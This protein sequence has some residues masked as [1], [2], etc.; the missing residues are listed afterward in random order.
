M[1]SHDFPQPQLS[2]QRYLEAVKA[3]LTALAQCDAAV[4]GG[5]IA[6][7]PTVGDNTLLTLYTLDGINEVLEWNNEGAAAD[8]IA[9]IWLSLLRWLRTVHHINPDA[10]PFALDRPLDH[11]LDVAPHS[12]PNTVIEQ[13][14]RTGE[15]QMID[16][17]INAD[18][19]DAG[20]LVRAVALGFLPVEDVQTVALLSARSTALTHGNHQIIFA[21]VAVS[22]MVRAA[23]GLATA[24]TESAP[25]SGVFRA[26]LEH[27]SAWLETP[28][29][30]QFPGTADKVVAVCQ[31]ALAGKI[32]DSSHD[33][34]VA[35]LGKVLAV[36]LNNDSVAGARAL[37]SQVI[38]PTT[39]KAHEFALIGAL[40]GV[41]Y[42]QD[43]L[44][45]PTQLAPSAQASIELV[46]DNWVQQLGLSR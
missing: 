21:S 33:G 34:A 46:L 26:S 20:S 11:A 38:K 9:C 25:E 7:S 4:C 3:S 44:E 24:S 45:S 36:L 19:Q 18:S 40:S 41:A 28:P 22:L 12:G 17:N 23:L 31:Q 1:N 8:E 37:L 2:T 13:A 35:I 15:M 6:A 42:G 30:P 39:Y 32:S 14:L 10:A 43:V 29:L 16:K 5:S 27:V